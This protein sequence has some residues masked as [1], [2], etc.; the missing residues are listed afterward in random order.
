MKAS[1]K[2][3]QAIGMPIL[4][5][6]RVITAAAKTDPNAYPLTSEQLKSMVPVR[7]FRG[8]PKSDHKK[9]LL[10][11][12]YSPEVVNYF[13]LTGPGWQSRMDRAL[14]WYVARAQHAAERSMGH[15]R[16][17]SPVI[18]KGVLTRPS[19]AKGV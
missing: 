16:S 7:A 18:R 11:I 3:R 5:E 13:R 9:L 1:N 15:A 10:S 19:V 2:K 17:V 14:C 12:R 6:D 4:K 8:R